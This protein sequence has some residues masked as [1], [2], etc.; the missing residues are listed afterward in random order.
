MSMLER[1]PESFD[2]KSLDLI[3]H[4]YDMIDTF[5][6]LAYGWK[7]K[8]KIIYIIMLLLGALITIVSLIRVNLPDALEIQVGK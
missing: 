2:Y 8:A 7:L 6:Y 1:L 5:N 3:R 4:A